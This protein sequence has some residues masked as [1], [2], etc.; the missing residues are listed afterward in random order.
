MSAEAP[1]RLLDPLVT[2][3]ED[4]GVRPLAQDEIRARRRPGAIVLF[5]AFQLAWGLVV[6]TPAHAWARAAWGAHPD[7]DAALFEPG[8]R[9]LLAWLT[10]PGSALPVTARTSAVLLLVGIVLG[11]LPLGVLLGALALGRGPRARSPRGA[12]VRLGAALFLPSCGVLALAWVLGLVVVGGAGIAG[13]FVDDGFA[14]SVGDRLAFAL[15]LVTYALFALAGAAVLVVADVTRAAITVERAHAGETET[16]AWGALGR[17]LRAALLLPR[18][19]KGA[20]AV[21]WAWRGALG[22]VLVGLGALAAA[23]LG[24]RG[25]AALWALFAAHQLV[26]FGRAALRASWLARALRAVAPPGEGHSGE[27]ATE[28]AAGAADAAA[29]PAEATRAEDAPPAGDQRPSER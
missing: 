24:G 18:R 15:R 25:G 28:D 29:A 10:S 26:I 6:A 3:D 4:D 13:S 8:A 27:V 7:G 20:L 12:A 23:A 17:G 21:A 1:P 2:R 9:A 5:W 14:P 22:V 16:T 19:E 11:Q